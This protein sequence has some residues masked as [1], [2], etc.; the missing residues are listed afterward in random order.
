MPATYG[1]IYAPIPNRM[2]NAPPTMGG[3]FGGGDSW[4]RTID[5]MNEYYRRLNEAAPADR[6]AVPERPPANLPV[7]YN[8]AGQPASGGGYD[9]MQILIALGLVGN[10][11]TTPVVGP[12]ANGRNVQY[13]GVR[14]AAASGGIGSSSIQTPSTPPA[15]AGGASRQASTTTQPGKSGYRPVPRNASPSPTVAPPQPV[16]MSVPAVPP[17]LSMRAPQPAPQIWPYRTSGAPM[18]R[19]PTGDPRGIWRGGW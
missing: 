1:P 17:A 9:P 4:Q 16:P 5:E 15:R 11:G 3:T 10:P 12:G 14:T 8:Q 7:P 18:S 19:Y 2:V 6:L 13:P